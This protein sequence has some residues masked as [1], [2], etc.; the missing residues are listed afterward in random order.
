MGHQEDMCCDGVGPHA[1]NIQFSFL[2]RTMI[3]RMERAYVI[4]S[5]RNQIFTKLVSYQLPHLDSNK[6]ILNNNVHDWQLSTEL[7]QLSSQVCLWSSKCAQ[8]GHTP[9]DRNL[10]LLNG[11][12]IP[13][14]YLF[15]CFYLIYLIYLIYF[16]FPFGCEGKN[17]ETSAS[18]SFKVCGWP[19]LLGP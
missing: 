14:V 17:G 5:R 16:F 2:W 19:L 18:Q 11:C 1:Q 12:L 3:N 6:K 13:M 15:V 4:I 10:K 7:I 8:S 9:Y